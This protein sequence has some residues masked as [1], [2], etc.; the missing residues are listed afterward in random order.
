M[1][2]FLKEFSSMIWIQFFSSVQITNSP[3][4]Q[5]R[6]P[7]LHPT[8]YFYPNLAS[9]RYQFPFLIITNVLSSPVFT[10]F[11]WSPFEPS[12]YTMVK[13]CGRDRSQSCSV[14]HFVRLLLTVWYCFHGSDLKV[15]S[16]PV[17]PLLSHNKK[18]L[19]QGE[20]NIRG[21]MGCF[22]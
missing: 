14:W 8:S 10:L 3:W 1:K 11:C 4:W 22:Y 7:D 17:V 13:Q 20:R 18:V 12:R 16:G 19:V 2:E 9:G 6:C 5:T 21:F 15:I